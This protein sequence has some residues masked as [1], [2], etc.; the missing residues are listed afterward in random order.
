[1]VVMEI[2]SSEVIGV[3]GIR[4]TD[5]PEGERLP[6]SL[7]F[8][9]VGVTRRLSFEVIFGVLFK[10]YGLGRESEENHLVSNF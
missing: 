3:D 4:E 2:N 1:M 5:L 10:G 8:G 6:D 7:F 9:L